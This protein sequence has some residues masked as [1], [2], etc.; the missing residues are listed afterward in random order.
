L[1]DYTVE[2]RLKLSPGQ[3]PQY[4]RTLNQFF[5]FLAG[6]PP[7]RSLAISFLDQYS[8]RSLATKQRYG[9]IIKGLFTSD[10]GLAIKDFKID[11][12]HSEP[13]P[14]VVTNEEFYKL[15][16]AIED[17][18]TYLDNI[19]RDKVLVLLLGRT[20]ARREGAANL[21]VSDVMLGNKPQIVFRQGKG[22]KDMAVPI[23]PELLGPLSAYIAGRKPSESLF[24][25]TKFAVS[26]VVSRYAKKA[27]VNIHAHSLRH[28]CAGWL[29][30]QGF[31]IREVQAWL[32]HARLET[33][34]VYLDLVP[35]ALHDAV[36][37][38]ES[39]KKLVQTPPI[40]IPHIDENQVIRVL[41]SFSVN[42]GNVKIGVI[43]FL[44]KYW[45]K[46]S[47]G[48][49]TAEFV[50]IFRQEYGLQSVEFKLVWEALDSI[51]GYLDLHD[52][53]HV[54][55]R[56]RGTRRDKLDVDFW[57]LTGAGKKLILEYEK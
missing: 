21:K 55:Q 45:P 25:L 40:Q 7:S 53:I 38:V 14:Q 56:H 12:P 52:I 9:T 47:A 16:K 35:D 43:Q 36:R 22:R 50:T 46:F 30:R 23:L 28:Y 44:R 49:N 18:D 39:E 37:R 1:S 42:V 27:G 20:A 48:L 57:L 8:T 19:Q 34:G 54:E 51:L 6:R 4:L 17:R 10:S 11:M 13:L 41:E 24:G 31:T 3:F 26:D 29:L 5:G 32:G 2:L 15:I 33:T